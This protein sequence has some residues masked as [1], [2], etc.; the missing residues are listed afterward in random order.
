MALVALFA[1]IGLITAT[2]AFTTVEAERTADVQ[3]SGDQSA[4]LAINVADNSNAPEYVDDSG[5]QTVI[6]I[7][8]TSEG[9][10]GV[11]PNALTNFGPLLN[12]S[13]Q[14]TQDVGVYVEVTGADADVATLNWSDGSSAEGTS[15]AVTLT[16]GTSDELAFEIDL[17]GEGFS[18]NDELDLTITIIADADVAA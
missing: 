4:L 16:P 7:D 6:D 3:V 10:N 11:N 14:G 5:D 8:G 9:A 12:I 17:R 1:A 18:D 15:G 13:N 2:G